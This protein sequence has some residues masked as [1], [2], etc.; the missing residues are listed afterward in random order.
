MTVKSCPFCKANHK[1]SGSIYAILVEVVTEDC[2]R[3]C[4]ECTNCGLR[5]PGAEDNDE[6]LAINFWNEMATGMSHFWNNEIPL[7]F[8]IHVDSE[9][10]SDVI[11]LPDGWTYE[12]IDHDIDDVEDDGWGG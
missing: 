6:E 9:C 5:G 7:S 8:E 2:N 12:L 3:V 10:V 4:V 11:G 1:S